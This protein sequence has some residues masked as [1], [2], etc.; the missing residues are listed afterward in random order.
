MLEVENKR[1]DELEVNSK[2]FLEE[3]EKQIYDEFKRIIDSLKMTQEKYK[4]ENSKLLYEVQ[5]LKRE[6]IEIQQK[7]KELNI[8]LAGIQKII[9]YSHS[10]FK[11]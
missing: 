4:N 9:G 5:T 2:Y 3:T 1:V 6:K 8:R 10:E 7:I 11:F